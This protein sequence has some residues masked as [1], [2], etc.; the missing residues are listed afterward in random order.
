MTST[1]VSLRKVPKRLK[2]GKKSVYYALRWYSQDG[3]RRYSQ[4]VGK[5]GQVTKAEAESARRQKE[6]DLGSARIPAQ[7]GLE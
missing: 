4:S 7:S 1:R 5:V 2:G 6:I 3:T